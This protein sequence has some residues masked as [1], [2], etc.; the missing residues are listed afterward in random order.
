MCKNVVFIISNSDFLQ[1]SKQV[2]LVVRCSVDEHTNPKL[3]NKLIN[4]LFFI[5]NNHIIGNYILLT[6]YNATNNHIVQES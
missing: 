6:V 3:A 5:W 4:V 1:L 2:S